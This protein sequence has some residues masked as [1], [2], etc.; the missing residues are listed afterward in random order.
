MFFVIVFFFFLFGVETCPPSCSNFA[1]DVPHIDDLYQ[2]LYIY[3][4]QCWKANFFGVYNLESA[5]SPLVSIGKQPH[6]LLGLR[7]EFLIT[8]ENFFISHEGIRKTGARACWQ[9]ST[10]LDINFCSWIIGHD[11]LNFDKKQQQQERYK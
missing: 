4:S 11:C 3:S 6:Q 10:S 7:E 9:P 8:N 5:L 2:H 1:T